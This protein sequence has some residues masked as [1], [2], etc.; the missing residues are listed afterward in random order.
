M[1]KITCWYIQN[2]D[3]SWSYNHFS[4]GWKVDIFPRAVNKAQK[5]NWRT[6]KWKQAYA[7][8]TDDG[9]VSEAAFRIPAS[10][11]L[12]EHED[13]YGPIAKQLYLIEPRCPYGG[14]ADD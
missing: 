14:F 5:A 6:H 11:A 2:K 3:G 13:H 1:K 12:E 7:Y 4:D 10:V 9:L 8:M